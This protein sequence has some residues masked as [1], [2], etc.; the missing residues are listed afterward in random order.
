MEGQIS[1]SQAE[2]VESEDT[3]QEAAD[4]RLLPPAVKE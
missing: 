4:S 2:Q 1:R 3:K